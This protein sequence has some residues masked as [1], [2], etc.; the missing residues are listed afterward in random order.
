M[1]R[2]SFHGNAGG[3]STDVVAL[4]GNMRRKTLIISW[5]GAG[6]LLIS[7]GNKTLTGSVFDL[8]MIS[9]QGPLV[10]T[11]EAIGDALTEAV[12]IWNSTASGPAT[13]TEFFDP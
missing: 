7:F 5:G 9:N 10:L 4:G 3:G 12:Y 6:P 1:L 2:N 8:V 11:R 13:I